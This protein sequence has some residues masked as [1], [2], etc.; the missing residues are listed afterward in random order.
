MQ[1]FW[2]FLGRNASL[3]PL[4]GALLVGVL[5]L[6]TNRKLA[7]AK[8]SIDLQNNFLASERIHNKMVYVATIHKS[9]DKAWI[10]SLGELKK[11]GD[12]TIDQAEA[13]ESLRVVLNA[14]ERMAIGVANDIYDE[15]LLY[16]SYA[17][18]VIQ[19]FDVYGS[20]LFSKTEEGRC[21]YENFSTMASRW[22]RWRDV[23]VKPPKGYRDRIN[24][25][26]RSKFS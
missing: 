7:R 24:R 11:A 5:T 1:C 22:K 9:K 6:Y 3:V 2:D 20:Y 13:I 18:F 4:T 14:F 12:V 23:G 25:W 19:T 8:N 10:D 15:C 16:D 26:A 17:T 21:Y